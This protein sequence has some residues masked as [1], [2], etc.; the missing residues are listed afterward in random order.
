MSS[1]ARRQVSPYGCRSRWRTGDLNSIE[2]RAK[3]QELEKKFSRLQLRLAR[4]LL[5]STPH[6]HQSSRSDILPTLRAL[7]MDYCG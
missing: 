5:R 6:S 3:P 1:V 7:T 4:Q 2:L